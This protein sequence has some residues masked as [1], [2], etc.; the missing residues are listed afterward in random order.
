M[1]E[2]RLL[3]CQGGLIG[4]SYGDLHLCT[5]R[6]NFRGA[7][8]PGCQAPCTVNRPGFHTLIGQDVMQMS[9]RRE[10]TKLSRSGPELTR[11][12]ASGMYSP[13]PPCPVVSAACTTRC[14]TIPPRVRV[15]RKVAASNTCARGR[16]RGQQP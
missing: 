6:N 10:S 5:R 2:R 1:H 9:Y 16:A 13:G 7:Q 11:R 12:T 14:R 15:V 4:K 8:R 3:H